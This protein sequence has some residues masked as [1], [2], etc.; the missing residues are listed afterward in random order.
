[1]D[2]QQLQQWVENI[3][4][5][6]FG[7]PFRHQASFNARLRTTGGR[8]FT[9]SHNIEISRRQFE[10]FGHDEVEKII[11]HELCHYHLH[12]ERRGFRHRDL[13]FK[14][15]LLQVGGS[16][17]CSV[18]PE[19]RNRENYRFRLHCGHC[20]TEYLRKRQVDPNRYVCGKCRGRLYL[21]ALDLSVK[22]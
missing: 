21:E 3:S 15:L 5:T 17:Y 9:K 14:R 19:D 16:R 20:G 7:K 18:H 10:A 6:S 2:N 11:K 8:Y 4:L 13:D 12:L 1:M 22:A